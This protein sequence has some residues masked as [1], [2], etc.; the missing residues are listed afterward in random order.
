M[1]PPFNCVHLSSGFFFFSCLLNP[2]AAAS[3]SDDQRSSVSY[4]PG[5]QLRSTVTLGNGVGT[6][7]LV[8]SRTPQYQANTAMG[9]CHC[10]SEER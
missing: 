1:I 9:H 10:R 4:G 3:L 8:M 6:R 7:R 2:P 5:A